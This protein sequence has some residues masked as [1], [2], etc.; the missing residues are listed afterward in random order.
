MSDSAKVVLGN[1]IPKERDVAW[2][3]EAPCL[4]TGDLHF[5]DQGTKYYAA[6]KA[7]ALAMCASCPLK[8]PCLEDALQMHEKYG[9]RGGLTAPQRRPLLAA[10]AAERRQEKGLAA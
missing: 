6:Q 10:R 2:M 8:A 7:A 4:D 3:D 1:L 5:P 9:I